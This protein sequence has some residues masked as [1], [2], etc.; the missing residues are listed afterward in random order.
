M[1][2]RSI[3]YA[4]LVLVAIGAFLLALELGG[5]LERAEALSKNS[6]HAASGSGTAKELE[7][8]VTELQRG[9]ARGRLFAAASAALALAVGLALRY[10]LIKE[11]AE[12]RYL[13][14]ETEAQLMRLSMDSE[15]ARVLAS[16]NH[17]AEVFGETRDVDA[18]LDEAVR[19][20]REILGVDNLVLELYGSEESLL[21][22]HKVEGPIQDIDLGEELYEDVVGRGASRLIN[23]LDSVPHFESLAEKG[24]KSLL[25]TPLINH[26][27]GGIK[28]PV[29]FIA[30][31]CTTQRDFTTHE[32]SLLKSFADQASLIIENA[33]LHEKTQQL[34]I[35]DG[36]TNLY[37]HR[38]FREVLDTLIAEAAKTGS[39]LALLLGDIDHFKNYNDTF[40]HLKGDIVL[41]TVGDIMRTSV[42]GA[43]TVARYGG[44]EFV[45]LLP[46]TD[47]HGARLVG[48]NI[49][50]KIAQH[51][52]EGEEKQPGGNLTITFGLA[53]Y[54]ADATDAETLIDMADRALYAG[55]RS[56]RNKLVIAADIAAV[57]ADIAERERTGKLEPSAYRAKRHVGHTSRE[58]ETP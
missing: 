14:R 28:E 24:F 27:P 29:G 53:M 47:L 35:R 45:L 37:N 46:N 33:Q 11:E 22:R 1:A 50:T 40:G 5:A 39:P 6:R 32:L 34:A 9:L 44:E 16:V 49:R 3:I 15:R 31:L 43:D 48:E 4:S 8:L 18:V 52:F 58:S 17:L 54:P 25:V 38:R 19:A 20:I 42:R 10:M 21:R 41:R 26:K 36:L 2:L 7:E 51:H 23:R 57:E 56:G 13:G 12:K 55:K 30:A